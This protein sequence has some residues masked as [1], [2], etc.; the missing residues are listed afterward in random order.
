MLGII[1]FIIKKYVYYEMWGCYI[2][3]LYY[4]ILSSTIMLQ[5]LFLIGKN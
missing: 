3:L 2:N 5:L 1:N 4:K